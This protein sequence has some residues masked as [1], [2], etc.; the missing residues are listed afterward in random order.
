MYIT[1]ATFPKFINKHINLIIVRIVKMSS[2]ETVKRKE[3]DELKDEV[4][5][6]RE[7][8]KLLSN[9]EVLKELKEAKKRI[10]EGKGI[11]LDEVE[12]DLL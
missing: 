11:P 9:P 10:D 6:M 4:E 1:S 3:F 8:M 12:N 2:V 5:H 7:N